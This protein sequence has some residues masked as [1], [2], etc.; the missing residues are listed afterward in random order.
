MLQIL[1]VVF[2]EILEIS[3][4]VGI[5][6]AATK[7]IVNRNKYIALGLI[8][9][10]IGSLILAFFTD[11]I[12][13]SLDGVG[14]EIFNGFVLLSAAIM[15]SW[16]VIWMQKHAKS[17][18]GEFK[19]LG[20]SIKQGKKP[21]IALLMV[22]ALS[23]LREGA[24]IVLFSYGAYVSGVDIANILMGISLGIFM[25][26]ALGFALYLGLLKVFGKYFFKVTTV[27]LVLLACGVTSQAFGMWTSSGILSPIIE[28]LW[29]SSEIISQASVFGQILNIFTGYIEKPSAIQIIAYLTNLIII[30]SGLNIYKKNK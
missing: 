29:D 6:T 15:I 3:L 25:G 17:L 2:R 30:I 22:V 24:E 23:V 18:S 12:S 16:T 9:G 27:I 28:E 19:E 26:T 1:I 7:H 21:P 4:I 14:Q 20:N 5:L 8:I 13:Q 11:L 10:C